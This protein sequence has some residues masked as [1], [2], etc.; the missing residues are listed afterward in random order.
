MATVD[1][2]L[3]QVDGRMRKSVEALGRELQS[4]RTGRASPA[5]I[6]NLLVDYYGVP[7][8]VNQI[9]SISVPEGRMLMIQPWDQ[10]SVKDVEKGVLKSD[11][12]LV[13]NS[14]GSAIRINI[15]P[16]TEE[17]RKDLVRLVGRKAE[18]AHVS[19]RNIRRDGLEQIRTLEKSK[20]ISK[21]DERRALEQLQALTDSRIGD[22]DDLKVE[23]DYEVMEV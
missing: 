20:E 11:L 18:E 4:I 7:T 12:G 22:M 14:D 23:K 1:E 9:A 8:P 17:R 2:I 19:V 6:E 13:P 10:Q 15:P 5:L 3:K 21:D 16:L